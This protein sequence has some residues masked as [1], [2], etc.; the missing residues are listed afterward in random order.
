MES[1]K[2]RLY[3]E[4]QGVGIIITESGEEVIV[5]SRG[6]QEKIKTGDVVRFETVE[7]SKG[8]VAKDV[9]LEK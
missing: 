7:T 3:N 2:V 8:L 4:E 6:L 9:S 1:G 5:K